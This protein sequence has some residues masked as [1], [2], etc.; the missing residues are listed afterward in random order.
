MLNFAS[1]TPSVNLLGQVIYRTLPTLGPHLKLFFAIMW[2]FAGMGV[3]FF[4]GLMGQS[5]D[6]GGPGHWGQEYVTVV[7]PNTTPQRQFPDQSYPANYTTSTL[8]TFGGLTKATPWNVPWMNTA[9]GGGPYFY[10][11]NF[12]GMAQVKGHKTQPRT[13]TRSLMPV[14]PEGDDCS[15]GRHHPRRLGS[16]L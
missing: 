9:Y 12:D 13:R 4:C 10:Q 3:T 7:D 11:I 5:Q 6:L 14:V 15:L 2:G 1:E 8:Q 16:D